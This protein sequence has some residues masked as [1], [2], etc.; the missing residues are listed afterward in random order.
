MRSQDFCFAT[1]SVQRRVKSRNGARQCVA[2]D[3][4]TGKIARQL[5]L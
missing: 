2:L 3:V 1:P 5:S 4:E